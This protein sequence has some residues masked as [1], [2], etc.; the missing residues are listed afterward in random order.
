MG[1]S[2]VFYDNLLFIDKH[3]FMENA[4]EIVFV[5]LVAS[6]MLLAFGLAAAIVLF[7]LIYQKRLAKQALKMQQLKIEHQETLIQS[8]I[9]VS[10]DE[11]REFA[12]NLH[13]EIGAQLAIAKI[14]LSSLGEL[15]DENQGTV[16]DTLRIMDEISASIRNISYHFMP[17]VL[18]KLGLEKAIEDYLTKIPSKQIQ[19]SFESTIEGKRF[20]RNIEL[21]AYRI[22][23]EAVSNALRHAECSHI[24]VSLM[25]QK[26]WF[27]L[28]I[29]DNGKG[30]QKNQSNGTGMLNMENR[31]KL[32][33]FDWHVS[34]SEQGTRICISPK[35]TLA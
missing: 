27:E 26:R 21:H 9:Q 10:E 4:S 13:D 34:S 14:T 32:I 20:D 25:I 22:I 5:K 29:S 35:N 7:V 18:V 31:A 23:Q 11:R 3:W 1:D 28:C 30:I 2:P 6:G 33:Q 16:K 24:Q 17:P 8:A 12:S 19:T 15:E